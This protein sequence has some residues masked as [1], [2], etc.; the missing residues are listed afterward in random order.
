MTLS[1]A[2]SAECAACSAGS[3]RFGF[4]LS[5][6]FFV[7]TAPSLSA[8]LGLCAEA[9]PSGATSATRYEKPE[10]IDFVARVVTKLEFVDVERQISRAYLVEITDDAA[11]D[12]GPEAL[13]VL[14]V[15]RAD[16]VFAF[17]VI[18]NFV[19]VAG[20]QTAI[21][22]PLISYEQG[23]F[24]GYSLAHKTLQRRPIDAFD[25]AGRNFAF[26]A[27]RADDWRLAGPDTASSAA[28]EPLAFVA[29]L[30][31]AANEGFVNLYFAE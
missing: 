5:S 16:D 15:N 4:P 19:R 8:L 22:N 1:K 31:E 20:R 28:L 2:T 11:F 13:N 10:R 27:D 6:G 7:G 9:G 12:E 25:D 17:G 18:D 23:H 26:A 21:T 14:G 30:G 3:S 29:V 24:L